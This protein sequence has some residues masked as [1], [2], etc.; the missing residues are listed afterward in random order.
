MSAGRGRHQSPAP[1]N[2]DRLTLWRTR[3]R[4]TMRPRVPATILPSTRPLFL[5][6][7]PALATANRRGHNLP[8]YSENCVF[9]TELP[10]QKARTEVH[11]KCLGR[12]FVTPRINRIFHE[13]N[14]LKL[15]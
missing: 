1:C 6:R 4:S 13:I 5:S 8:K 7:L 14:K 3:T 12:K 10:E 15:P 11:F 2:R 9:A